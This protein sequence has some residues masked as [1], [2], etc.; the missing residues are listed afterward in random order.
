MPL[1]SFY[2]LAWPT[3]LS[4]TLLSTSPIAC[5]PVP[6]G[7][8]LEPCRSAWSHLEVARAPALFPSRPIQL[9][10]R[11]GYLW[12]LSRT[13]AF[14][15]W[16]RGRLRRRIITTTACTSSVRGIEWVIHIVFPR[17][18][19]VRVLFFSFLFPNLCE[20]HWFQREYL[21]WLKDWDHLGSPLAMARGV[22]EKSQWMY[23]VMK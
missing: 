16:W 17:I 8:P 7:V 15:K 6:N 13:A 12:S 22:G 9:E 14:L 2:S 11:V 23:A 19:I 1:A 5:C 10:T 20:Y 18:S 21:D 3:C 4:L